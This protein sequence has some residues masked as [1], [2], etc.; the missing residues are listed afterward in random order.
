MTTAAIVSL[1]RVAPLPAGRSPTRKSGGG[2]ARTAAFVLPFRPRG[3]ARTGALPKLV[4]HEGAAIAVAPAHDPDHALVRAV[5]AGSKDAMRTLFL[6]YRLRVFRFIVCIVRDHA[7]AEDLVSDVFL[8]VWRRADRFEGRSSVSTWL[9][10][11]A[12]HKALT[13]LQDNPPLCRDDEMMLAVPDA[14]PGPEGELAAKDKIALL[15][16]CLAALSREHRQ[17]IDLVYFR[18]KSIKEIAALLG[19]GLNTVKSRM[20][21]ARRRLARLMAD[22][23]YEAAGA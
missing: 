6:R 18:E 7:R 10:G 19:I 23:G 8:D 12:R 2:K 17:I 14:A 13:A 3:A 11:I 4:V 1:S 20:F 9:C 15:R 5:A 16:R 21:Y 22:G